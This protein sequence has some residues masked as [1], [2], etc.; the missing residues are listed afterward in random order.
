MDLTDPTE[1]GLLDGKTCRTEEPT[2]GALELQP[3]ASN[4]E[5]I[6]EVGSC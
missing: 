5:K 4:P 3:R 6:E 2:P 1:E